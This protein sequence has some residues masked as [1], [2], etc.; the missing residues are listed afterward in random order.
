ML[1]IGVS[2]TNESGAGLAAA[3]DAPTA[4]SSAG[5]EVSEGVLAAADGGDS[6]EGPVITTMANTTVATNPALKG[7]IQSLNPSM[8][9]DSLLVLD[10]LSRDW[11][12]C[13]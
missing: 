2:A 10:V 6:V 8:V 3:V 11:R 13:P 4:G 12:T 7:S 5:A 1:E 9:L